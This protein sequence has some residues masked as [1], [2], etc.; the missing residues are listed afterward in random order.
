MALKKRTVKWL[1]KN[2]RGS[3]KGKTVLITGA[4]SGVGFKSAELMAFLG[5]RVIMACRNKEKAAAAREELICACPDA[6]I[7]IMRLDL[8]DIASIESFVERMKEEKT[9]IDVFL[10][11]AGVFRK[12]GMKTKDGFDLVIGTDYIG[13]A[14][15]TELA[16]PYLE[17][18]PHEVIF[19]NTTSII[20]KLGSVDLDDFC[21]NRKKSYNGFAV[22]ARAKLCLSKYTYYKAGQYEGRGV[23]VLM[24]HPG[25]AIT[26]LGANAFG[27]TVSRLA[28]VLSWV[29]NSAE[30]SALSLP[31]IMEKLPPAGSISGPRGFINGWG[32]PSVNKTCRRVKT[33]GRELLEFTL[34]LID[35]VKQKGPAPAKEDNK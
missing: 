10:N 17:T 13:A 5:A 28:G 1:G 8:A 11:N 33:G 12:P 7:T 24:S 18:L 26:P 23:R 2:C 14:Y 9:D 3:Y 22:Y 15:L 20:H 4:N 19:I 30:T 6:D 35:G 25:I 32:L 16:L 31:F 21:Y 29:F 34:R 27:K